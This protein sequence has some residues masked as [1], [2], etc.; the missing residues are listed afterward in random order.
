M[1][2]E[3]AA[4]GADGEGKQPTPFQRVIRSR[5][6]VP[7]AVVFSLVF[8]VLLSSRLAGRPPQIDSIIPRTG[9]PGDVMIV[10]GRY[11]G[12]ERNGEVRISGISPTSGE[13][14]QWTDTSISVVIPDEAGSGLVYVIT[15]NGKSGGK[16][17]TNSDQIPV[18]VSS[19]ARP[20][21]P[22]IDA[23][24]PTAARIGDVVS[25]RGKNFGLKKGGSDVYFSWVAGVKSGAD[26]PY[27]S[28]NQV[29]AL[30][31]N[32]DYA[33]WSDIEIRLRVPD[34]A[35]SGNLLIRTDKGK[36]NS[37]Y[38]EV[39]RGAGLKYFSDP[40]KYSV[41]YG[42]SL[43]DVAASGDNTLYLWM[44]LIVSV[45]EQRGVQLVSREPE[46]MLE[47][48]K[49]LALFALSNL[50]KGGRY[51]VA[52][53]YMVDR[54]AVS[55]QIDPSKVRAYDASSDVYR[56]FTAPDPDV[57][58]G[59]PEIQK[60]LPS[61]LKGETNPYLKV[62]RVYDFIL[63]KLL[64]A[65]SPPGPD[66]LTA[67]KN[68][69]GGD[70][71]YAALTCAFVRAAGVPARMI[72]GYLVGDTGQPTRR[73]FWAEFY[74]ETLGWVPVDALLGEGGRD[75]P[76][77]NAAAY[78]FGNLD[79]RHITLSKG[80]A[81]VNQMEPDDS[82]SRRKELPFLSTISEEATPGITAYTADFEDLQ[83]TGVY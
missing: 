77:E 70:F 18:P 31:S 51:R 59:S 11:F 74:I 37:M 71:D 62:K 16:L 49:G 56:S 34:G 26:D 21:E 43:K 80:L 4:F 24:Q 13:Y 60:L 69:S 64:Y 25:I 66:S 48:S 14:L 83:V 1:S 27:T 9:K 61:I 3:Q 67:L 75:P 39:L 52:M 29:P 65:S 35:A 2:H 6:F 20:G 82:I 17:F 23:I 72:S 53:S 58:S 12:A 81:T 30:D 5:A 63:A 45:P 78:Y 19:L 33:S 7:S 54:Y 15:K 28:E 41:E 8:L 46:P 68:G 32:L 55:V 57:P 22:L 50:Q 42:L 73:H 76:M 79:N 40:R 38:F 36:S 10:T 47:D 44:P